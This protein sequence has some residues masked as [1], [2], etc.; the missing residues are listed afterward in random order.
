MAACMF[1]AAFYVPLLTS[2]HF[3]CPFM[4][5]VRPNRVQ[6]LEKPGNTAFNIDS[7]SIVRPNI[8]SIVNKA[9]RSISFFKL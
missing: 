6:D 1:V 5:C 7:I 8:V 2:Q 9:K 4:P 3:C